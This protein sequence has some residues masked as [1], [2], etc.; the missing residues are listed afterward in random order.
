[1]LNTSKNTRRMKQ[2]LG[3]ISLLFLMGCQEKP[4][5]NDNSSDLLA[6]K[7][8]PFDQFFIQRSFPDKHFPVRAY[9]KALNQVQLERLSESPNIFEGDWTV[10]GPGNLGARINT[11]ALVPNSSTI[12]VGFA[13]GGVWKTV[14]AGASWKPIFD[15]QTLLAIGDIVVDP[16]DTS[17][18]YV[19]TGDP[20]ITSYPGIGNGVYKSTNSGQTWSYLGLSET[21]ITSKIIVNPNNSNQIFVATMGLPFERN[22]DRGLYRTDDGGQTWQKVLFI[23]DQAGVIDL[24][25]NPNN[26]NELFAVGWDRLR[27]NQESIVY[28]PN[29]KI[30]K[31]T[32]SG[33]DWTLL[34]NG[35]P[36]GISSRPGITISESNPNILYALYVGTNFQISGVYKSIDGGASWTA[37]SLVGLNNAVGGFGWYFGQIRV[38]PI[39]PDK[40]YIL[41]TGIRHT[42]NGGDSWGIYLGAQGH[43][44]KHDLVFQN[45]GSF[46][47]TDGGLY[48][49]VSDV[50]TLVRIDNIPTNEVYRVGYNPFKPD[51]YYCGTQD[52]GSSRGNAANINNWEIYYG[53]DGFQ[54][55]FSPVDSNVFYASAQYGNMGRTTNG[56]LNFTSFTTGIPTTDRKN[57]DSPYILSHIHPNILYIGTH[58]VYR[59]DTM[60][61][62]F[63]PSSTD[64]TNGNIYGSSFHTIT[65]ID[66]SHFVEGEVYAGT[67]DANVHRRTPSGNW[68]NISAGL[69]VR[70][71]TSVKTSPYLSGRVFVTHSGYRDNDFIPRVHRSDDL[72]ANWVDI[73]SNLPDLAVNDILVIPNREDSVLVVATDGG[74]YATI[75]AGTLWKRVGD[76]PF[77]K[78]MDLV[79]NEENNSIVAGTFGR[80]VMTFPVDSLQVDGTFTILGD[81]KTVTG[82]T[83]PAEVAFIYPNNDTLVSE[84]L[85]FEG[86]SKF[87]P[88]RLAPKLDTLASDGVDVLD[89]LLI[90]QNVLGIASLTPEQKVAADVDLS[91]TIKVPDLLI[92]RKLTLGQINKFPATQSWRFYADTSLYSTE[93]NLFGAGDAIKID[94]L[95]V[96][97]LHF[98][99]IKMGDVN[100]SW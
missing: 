94:S 27:N 99:A 21:S 79:Y 84:I 43:P 40:V 10:Q 37:K 23:S 83:V 71:V 17:V 61:E 100:Y 16:N 9:Q 41:G 7:N 55:L 64:L 53:G 75:N 66:E 80:S 90:Y 31:T 81:I 3:L 44:D 67:S 76:M 72:G 68:I 35:L 30:Y 12:Y 29:A 63:M 11:I 13:N 89:L 22:T 93:T 24:V 60:T 2:I 78:V 50:E 96:D 6:Q 49:G 15:D 98:K 42:A 52:N 14:N 57:W 73:S 33:Q 19:G 45:G 65:T 77:V 34:T 4:V 28:G 85:H 56:G 25:M 36:Q 69:P 48:H 97:S 88:Y 39:D 92:L 1:M 74:V 26:P 54:T 87:G 8:Y 95:P 38:D 82:Q 32:N 46:V 62:S 51:T 20:N 58:K 5:I 70:Y 59:L 91:G 47:A 86:L 18:I